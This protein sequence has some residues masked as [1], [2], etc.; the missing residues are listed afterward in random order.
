MTQTPLEKELLEALR[1]LTQFLVENDE[2]WHDNQYV[3][4]AQQAITHA[5][6][7]G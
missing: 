4:D 3:L 1:S 2:R 5:E 7:K 6:G